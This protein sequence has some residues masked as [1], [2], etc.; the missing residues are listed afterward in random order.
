MLILQFIKLLEIYKEFQE[1]PFLPKVII[2]M[3]KPTV[4]DFFCGAGGF[5]EGFRQQGFEII[6]GVDNW[7]PA[8]DTFN[9][10]FGLSSEVL[11]IL[12]FQDSIQ[13]ILDLPD[14]DVIIGSP[15]CVSFS[16]SN[17][18]GKAS[19]EAGILLTEIFLRIVAVKKFQK[20]SKLKAWYMENVANSKKFLKKYYTFIDLNLYEWATKNGIDPNNKAV[21]LEGNQP[22]ILSADYGTP[23][24]RK[25]VISGE[26]IKAGKLLVPE[27][28]HSDNECDGLENWRTLSFVKDN[29]PAPNEKRSSHTISDPLYPEIRLRLDELTDHFYDSGLYECE[30]KQSRYLKINHP[31]MGRMSFPENES[32]PSRTIIATKSPTSRESFI[33]KSEYNR[34]GNGEYRSPTVREAACIMGFPITFQF[35]GSENNKWRLV[36]NAVCPSIGRAFAERLRRE[37]GLDELKTLDLIKSPNL[38]GVQNLNTFQEKKFNRQPKRIKNSRFRRHPIKDGNLTVTLSNYDIEQNSKTL[39][40]WLTSIQ[41]GTGE[42]FPIQQIPDNY[43]LKLEPII[44]QFE[45]GKDFLDRVNNGFSKKIAPAK[46]LQ[47][48]YEEQSSE[49]HWLEPTELVE[50]VSRLID[51][52]R[53]KNVIFKQEDQTIFIKE[54]VPFNQLLA[55]YAI[56]KISSL[57]NQKPYEQRNQNPKDTRNNRS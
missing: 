19:K 57:A 41:Y 43:F 42:G 30:W 46:E 50:E 26:V 4:I 9:H 17:N 48:M 52:S 55:L 23:Q 15:P 14:T 25:R 56:N 13:K 11:D 35:L 47:N 28:T 33:Y 49:N 29:L 27:P 20:N 18:S 21:I 37:L 8:I 12:E 44:E 24:L 1:I 7:K 32:R 40:K 5:S 54:A 53:T 6:Q 31:Y 10:N 36:G 34:N 38:L 22:L 16:S 51:N 39:G 45:G 2:H 3:A